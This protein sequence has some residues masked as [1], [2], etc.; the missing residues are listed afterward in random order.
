MNSLYRNAVPL[1]IGVG[2]IIVAATLWH[3]WPQSA[4]SGDYKFMHCEVCGFETAYNPKTAGLQC[5]HCKPPNF[6]R[7]IP[8]Q[9]SVSEDRPSPYR[10][11]I[12]VL[13]AEAVCILGALVF[14]LYHPPPP[15]DRVYYY[16]HCPNIK[17]RRKMRYP[18]SRA[19]APAQCPLCKTTLVNPTVEEQEFW[20]NPSFV[21]RSTEIP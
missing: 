2:A 20:Q 9:E 21:R 18:A 14:F 19:G 15:P 13:M 10:K 5:P 1:V 7:L 3:L 12:A 16:T 8:T 6:G 4:S 11:I 17:C